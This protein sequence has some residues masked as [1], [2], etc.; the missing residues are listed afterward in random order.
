MATRK[1]KKPADE[2][3]SARPTEEIETPELKTPEKE[4]SVRERR[5]KKE[6]AG[7]RVKREPP[8]QAERRTNKRESPPRRRIAPPPPQKETSKFRGL[9][10]LLLVG[11]MGWVSWWS[12]QGIQAKAIG[13]QY[14]ETLSALDKLY[15]GC[16]VFWSGKGL[17]KS[18]SQQIADQILG[19][20]VAREKEEQVKVTVV[21][22]EQRKFLA[23]ARHLG[24]DKLFQLDRKG[25]LYLNTSGCLSEVV[26]VKL[27]LEDVQALENQCSPP[28]N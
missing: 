22:G 1:L 23:Q 18:C 19:S 8:P 21:E 24:N 25:K 15:V 12:W 27:K 17:Y 2:T 20:K 26:F 6:A 9:A 11:A 10:I 7:L 3:V 16:K 13:K 4:L 5:L 14:N 28:A